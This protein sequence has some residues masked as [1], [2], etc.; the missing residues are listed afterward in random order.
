MKK[1]SLWFWAMLLLLELGFALTLVSPDFI[2]EQSVKEAIAVYETMGSEAAREVESRA[3]AWYT[4]VMV[5]PEI[6]KTLRDYFI[7]SEQAR[8]NSRGLE[9]LGSPLW[10]YVDDR[11][12]CLMDLSYWV[13]RRLS[14]LVSWLVPCSVALVASVL[15]GRYRRLIKQTN[16]NK[17]SGTRL[18]YSYKAMV[19]TLM[20]FVMTFIA[21]FAISPVIVPFIIVG[22]MMALGLS[23]GNIAKRI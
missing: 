12:T 1:D 15:C 11:I 13:F 22:L 8:R 10:P 7:P 4:A 18:M 5:E 17:A 20:L 2:R 21:P 16:F 19:I 6:E 9:N 23:I 14:L 3:T